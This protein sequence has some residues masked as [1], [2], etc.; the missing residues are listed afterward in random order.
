MLDLS[1]WT[2]LL[3]FQIFKLYNFLL[4]FQRHQFC[5]IP[6]LE[7]K[8]MIKIL[9]RVQNPPDIEGRPDGLIERPDGQLQLPFQN[10]AESFL[11]QDLVRTCC[12][13]VQTVTA[14]IPFRISKGK[15]ESSG[16]VK[17]V[18]TVLPC[19]S[20]GCTG[21]SFSTRGRVRTPSKAHL[22]GCMGFDL[23][24]WNLV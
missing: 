13:S 5:L 8:V 19:R 18:R 20:D 23:S 21:I 14:V 22:D 16:T 1:V 10:S 2:F 6:M 15:L 3:A 7:Q 11:Y 17:S 4:A 24:E 12:P 9:R